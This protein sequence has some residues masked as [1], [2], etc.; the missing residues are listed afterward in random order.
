[1]DLNA[2][3]L[4]LPSPLERAV[5]AA[6]DTWDRRDSTRRLWARDASLWTG[7]DEDRWLGWLTIAEEEAAR[8]AEIETCAADVRRE[9]FTDALLLGMGGS[10]LAPEV[11]RAT[12]GRLPGAPDFHVLDSTDPAEVRSVERRLDLS[13]TLVI[14]ASKSG[15][16][17]EPEILRRYFFARMEAALGGGAGRRFIAI[18]DPGS[19][20]QRIAEQDGFRR[21]F[22]GVPSI[23]G[24]YS[25]LSRF[26]LVP[27]AI[28]GIDLE[29][30]LS[31]SVQMV[32]ACREGSAR[33]NPGVVLGLLLG[34]AAR[35]G[36]DKLTLVGSPALGALGAW[37]EQLVAES[38]GK[39]GKAIIPVDGET[40]A[41]PDAYGAD[42]VFAA[43][44]MRGEADKG[45]RERLDALAAA[46]HPVVHIE[47]GGA[48]ALGQEFFRWEMA[49]AV[50]GALLGINP[51]D[52]PD[53]EASKVA[54]RA[55]TTAYESTGRL[56]DETPILAAGGLKVF[57]DAGNA[58]ALGLAAGARDVVALLRG[59][60]SRIRAGDY[61]ALLAYVERSRRHE[62]ILQRIR[63]RVRDRAR[64]ATCLGFGPRFL[65]STGQAYKG[66]PASG[67]FLQITCD[68]AEDLP[69]PG[70]RFTFGVVKAA[71]A[72]GDLAVLA[73]RGRRALR[74]HLGAD[75]ALGLEQLDDL[76]RQ[77]LGT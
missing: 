46:G 57:A 24:R 62:A 54:T 18:T 39:N 26:G 52:Q 73:E 10:S 38:T 21:I 55:L 27:G 61:F 64:V 74:I 11:M 76:V 43:F 29:R 35:L 75:V 3:R 36:R 7:R 68:D 33:A 9:G 20:L 58:A 4:Q 23:G 14:V 8:L 32:A 77:A 22:F 72:R 67:V 70:R 50:A 1:M 51:F 2:C 13:R 44:A 28:M 19:A 69:V 30:W 63:H 49:T 34:E 17:L 71:Q 6:A 12:F 60:F 25:A 16:T 47:V 42:R 53:V 65:H 15:T 31:A 41:P 40:L 37:L 59:H 5:A 56:P 48:Y 66:G 45:R